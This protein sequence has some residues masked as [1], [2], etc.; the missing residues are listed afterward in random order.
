MM[1]LIKS[2]RLKPWQKRNEQMEPECICFSLQESRERVVDICRELAPDEQTR[3]RRFRFDIHR[4]RFIVAHHRL[5]MVLSSFT[6]IAPGKLKFITLEY[7]KPCIAPEQNPDKISFNL[8]HSHEMGVIIVCREHDVGVD[9][10]Y[11]DHNRSFMELARRYFSP[12]EVSRLNQAETADRTRLFYKIWTMKEAWLKASGL[13]IRGL[14]LV[15]TGVSGN[16]SM[17]ITDWGRERDEC[18]AFE[19]MD[20]GQFQPAM[21]YIVSYTR[22]YSSQIVSTR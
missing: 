22:L 9:I 10:E 14:N 17:I 19:P 18:R 2:G 13:G 16:G 11:I 8:S 4:R 12:G 5:R 20:V 21:D 7:G 15:E 3:A 6:G 1:K